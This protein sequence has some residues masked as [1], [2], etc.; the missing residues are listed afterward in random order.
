MLGRA[1]WRI[2]AVAFVVGALLP[3]LID[4]PLYYS[5]LWGFVS[6]T[7]TFG[8]TG[9]LGCVLLAIAVSTGSRSWWGV[10]VGDATHLILD[11][12]L[13]LFS[14]EPSSTWIAVTWPFLHT[15]F[16][17]VPV[18]SPLQQLNEIRIPAVLISEIIGGLLLLRDYRLRKRHAGLRRT[19]D[20]RRD[21]AG[22]A[23]PA[24]C[25]D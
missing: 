8:H 21:G 17:S 16:A 4:K 7:R 1:R 25:E 24:D 23:R 2:P 19:S 14:K 3:D 15:H 13:D 10:A 22:P 20:P 18:R 12:F 6:G 9:L 11:L 5:R